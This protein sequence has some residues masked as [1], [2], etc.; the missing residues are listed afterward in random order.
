MKLSDLDLEY[1]EPAAR[2]AAERAARRQQA[3]AEETIRRTTP[4]A[5]EV[6]T[7]AAEA[8]AGKLGARVR[9]KKA[10]P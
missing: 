7:K 2:V 9:R 1:S 3:A 4:L 8:L 5:E 10:K 6:V